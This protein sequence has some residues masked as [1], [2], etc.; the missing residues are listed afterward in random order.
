M[1]KKEKMYEQWLKIL[2]HSPRPAGSKNEQTIKNWLKAAIAE[3]GYEASSQK[4]PYTSW[5][6]TYFSGL[7]QL[8]PV[9]DTI[10]SFPAVGST[11]AENIH[12]YVQRIGYT[13]IWDM[14]KWPRYAVVDKEGSVL[15][16]ITARPD[17]EVLSQTLLEEW[18]FP[19]LI[20]GTSTYSKWEESF[21]KGEKVVV[22]FSLETKMEPRFDGENI[23]V[24]L[25]N[26]ENKDAVVVGAHY[27]SMY[28]T[29]GAYDNASGTA[30]L[31]ELI[32]TIKPEQ[33]P[34]HVNIV[35]FGSEELLLSGSKAYVQSMKEKREMPRCMLNIDGIGRGEVLESWST[36]NIERKL[37]YADLEKRKLFPNSSVVIPPPPGS[38][39]HPFVKAGCEALMLTVNDQEIIHTFKDE[40]DTNIFENMKK[41]VKYVKFILEN[42]K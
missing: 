2:H 20:I 36:S 11:S 23:S 25:S 33:L 16:Y 31:L 18:A 29:R 22:S 35:F 17:G 8:H 39:H 24:S 13:N 7:K 5:Q 6:L 28:N 40:P 10:E 4:F 21:R 9:K 34:V 27:D 41:V 3:E 42:Y 30:V 37:A 1:H 12:G 14:Y 38:D 15:A 32:R 19:H 26:R